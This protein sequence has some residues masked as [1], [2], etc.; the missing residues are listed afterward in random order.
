[1]EGTKMR[2][3]PLHEVDKYIAAW[4]FLQAAKRTLPQSGSVS[5]GPLLG[6]IDELQDEILL[7]REMVV[8]KTGGSANGGD[9]E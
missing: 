3:E 8:D 5:T 6:D 2:E 9:S 1:M 7:R 4:W